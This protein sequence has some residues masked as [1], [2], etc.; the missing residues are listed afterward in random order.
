M[1]TYPN[2]ATDQLTIDIVLPSREEITVDLYSQTGQLI[3]KVFSGTAET[4]LTRLDV[5]VAELSG[6]FYYL[7]ARYRE[8]DFSQPFIKTQP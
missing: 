4:G 3:K 1:T 2:P 8:R 5:T 7:R 6:G